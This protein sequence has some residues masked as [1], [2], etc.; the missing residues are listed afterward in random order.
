MKHFILNLHTI[1]GNI[2]MMSYAQVVET[3]V[4]VT[5]K[6]HSQDYTHPD[7][8]TLPTYEMNPGF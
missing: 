4:N 8:H 2:S 3:F 7:D 1:V 5:T 6:G